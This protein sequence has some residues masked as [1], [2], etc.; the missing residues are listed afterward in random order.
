MIMDRPLQN[1]TYSHGQ[2][3]HQLIMKL[4]LQEGFTPDSCYTF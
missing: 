1:F 3:G 2:L 4:L